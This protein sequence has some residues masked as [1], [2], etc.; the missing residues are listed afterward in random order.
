MALECLET[1]VGLAPTA[2]SCF[3]DAEPDGFATTTSG[4][5]ILDPEFGLSIVE[6][7]EVEGWTVL[8]A[9]RAKGILQFKTDLSAALRTRFGSAISPFD[10][11]VGKIQ[12]TGTTTAPN[13]YAGFRIRLR[14]MVK[15][16][17]IVLKKAYIGVNATDTY[18]VSVTSNDPLFTEPAS[19][20][21]V[22]TANTFGAGTSLDLIELPMYS[23]SLPYDYLE[24]YISFPLDGALPL[25]NKL[26]CCGRSAAWAQ[27]M[28]VTGFNSDSD[29]PN[30]DYSG[31]SNFSSNAY[32][33]ALD[34]YLSCG[35][36][37][38]ICDLGYTNGYHMTQVVARTLQFAQS[39]AAIDRLIM[40]YKVNVC[41]HYNQAEMV[42]R[43]NFLNESYAN[44]VA[45]IAANL[46]TGVTGCFNCNPKSAFH[47][48]AQL[49]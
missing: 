25:N 20:N 41:T 9:A 15:G 28:D 6:A 21:V 8:E 40:S 26:N 22:A 42:S 2:P 11:L 17:K 35:E 16:G 45:W 7:C 1:L 27:H 48:T 44:N 31:N 49:V 14:R 13:D 47:R 5:H 34:L 12:S 30:A 37:D 23:D 39:I 4:Y 10:G 19:V 36:L 3:V 24:Y 18:A 33:L 29:T 38:W 32:G 46:P 43:R